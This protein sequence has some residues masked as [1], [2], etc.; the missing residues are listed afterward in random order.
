M[1]SPRSTL[2]AAVLFAATGRPAAAQQ[3]AVAALARP[4]VTVDAAP[5][6]V[7][8]YRFA[9]PR[10]TGLPAQ[11]TVADSAGVL[12]ASFRLAGERAWRPMTIAVFNTGLVLQGETPSGVLT[13]ELYVQNE[14]MA[15]DF[16]GRWHLGEE[17]GKLRGR[18]T[19]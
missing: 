13:L 3:I 10:R 19:R 14:P 12:V 8:E 2:A 16:V 9:A 1:F 4:V 6:T 17:S 18:T 11:M 5:R 15:G 7:A